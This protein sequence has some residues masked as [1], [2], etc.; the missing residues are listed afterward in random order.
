[1]STASVKEGNGVWRVAGHLLKFSA[2]LSGLCL[3]VL[4]LLVSIAV[5]FR[6]VLN[7][8]IL[9][10]QEMVEIGMSLVV[11]LAMPYATLQGAHIRVD[12]LD[13]AIGQYG[14][15]LG[16]IFARLVSCFVLYLLIMKTWAKALDSHEYGDVTNMIELPVS[17]AYAAITFGFCL[18]ILV[19]LVKLVAQFLQGPK[20][21]E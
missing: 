4:M 14:R 18:T 8:P 10:D 16:D 12:I 13:K 15:F 19:I 17:V 11:M 2:L 3:F 21:Y 20:D 9:G 7:Q 6:Y 1:M 5:F